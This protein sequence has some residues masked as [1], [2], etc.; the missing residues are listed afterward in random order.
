MAYETDTLEF[1]EYFLKEASQLKIS[2]AENDIVIDTVTH[3]LI[4]KEK[5][6]EVLECEV[7][8]IRK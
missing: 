4:E 1:K 7:V 5:H 2:L 8:R 3:R 6:N